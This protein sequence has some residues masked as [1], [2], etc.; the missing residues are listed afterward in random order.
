MSEIKYTSSW[1]EHLMNTYVEVVSLSLELSWRV[2]PVGHDARDG[3]LNILHPL[4]H[5][6]VAHLVDVLDEVV[7]LL[8]ERHVGGFA[9]STQPSDKNAFHQ[10]LMLLQEFINMSHFSCFKDRS[11]KISNSSA[12]P[13]SLSIG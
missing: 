6:G 12:S 1:T 7:V 10:L 13:Q 8:P 3:L 4:G 5:L 2:D 9:F 11:T